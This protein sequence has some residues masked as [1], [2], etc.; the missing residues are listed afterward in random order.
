M[1][2]SRSATVADLP[3]IHRIWWA[4]DPFDAFND[5]PWF[6]HVLRTGS[7]LVATID[8]RPIGFAGARQVGGTTVVSDCFVLP[9]HQGQG[10][11]TELLS[12]LVPGDRPVMTLASSDPKARALYTSFGMT[13]QWDC[14]YLEGDPGR[15]ERVVGLVLEASGYPVEESDPMHLRD[16]LRCRFLETGGGHAAVA[17]DE[18][19]S[20]VVTPAGDPVGVLT[21][22]LGWAADRGDHPVKLHLSDRHPAFPGLIEAGFVVT[23]ADTLMA[24]PGA[25]VPDPTRVTF[26]GDILRLP[27]IW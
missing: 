21:A 17:V 26:N 5:N 9:D 2:D 10:V 19:E 25:Q 22:V 13:V 12:R 7:M 20:S 16:D 1:I 14:H 3:E 4:A 18:I 6:G 11:G 24:S 8:V 23:G 27:M 15:V